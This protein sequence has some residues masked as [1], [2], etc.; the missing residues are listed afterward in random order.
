MVQFLLAEGQGFNR[1]GTDV[2]ILKK[3]SPK[4]FAKKSAFLTRI[5]AKF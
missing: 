4:N 1:T 2:M 3:F 5:K